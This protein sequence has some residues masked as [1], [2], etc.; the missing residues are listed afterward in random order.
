MIKLL[1]KGELIHENGVIKKASSSVTLIQ[2]KNHNIIVDTSTKDKRDIIIE[3]L[4]KLNLEPKD[5]DVVINTHRHYDHIENNDLFEN[6]K[7]YASAQECIVE[8]EGCKL[9]SHVE[10][11]KDFIPVEKFQDDEITIIK[12]PGHT[13]GSISVVYGDYIIVG[14]AAPLK[15]NI[16]GDVLPLDIVDYRA[17]KGSLR[18]IKLLKKNVITGHDGIVYREE[19]L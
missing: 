3:E 6:A 19:F 13:Y 4:K 7:I 12:T 5:I 1:Y 2:T 18:R 16:L 8:C 9:Y 10:D 15:E 17:A 11:V 14:D